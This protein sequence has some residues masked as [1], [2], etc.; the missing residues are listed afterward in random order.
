MKKVSLKVLKSKKV[1]VV[2][3]VVVALAVTASVVFTRPYF[4]K[5]SK[6]AVSAVIAA[7]EYANSGYFTVQEIRYQKNSFA[8]EEN[9]YVYYVKYTPSEDASSKDSFVVEVRSG[10]VAGSTAN[11]NSKKKLESGKARFINLS[12]K[13]AEKHKVN[14]DSITKK[15]NKEII[16]RAEQSTPDGE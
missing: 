2:A 10:I 1:L 14:V 13:A 15:V 7:E 8:T 11:L 5:L 4:T 12:W 3:A 16:K 6:G 9:P